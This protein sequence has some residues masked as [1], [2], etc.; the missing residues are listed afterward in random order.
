MN[1]EQI[2]KWFKLKE[3][4][5]IDAIELLVDNCAYSNREAEKLVTEWQEENDR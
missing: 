5:Y 3:I 1:V 2:K 4:E